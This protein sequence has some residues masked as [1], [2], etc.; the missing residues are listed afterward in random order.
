MGQRLKNSP[1]LDGITYTRNLEAAYRN[2]WKKWCGLK[3][4]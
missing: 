1:M 2:V 4:R 3:D